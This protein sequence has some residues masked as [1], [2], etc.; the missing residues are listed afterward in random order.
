MP[1]GSNNRLNE[2]SANRNNGNRLFDSQN[3]N[4]GGYNKGDFAT[5]AFNGNGQS[6][7]VFAGEY[8]DGQYSEVYLEGSTI[9][10]EWTAQHGCGGNEKDDPHKLNCNMVIQYTCNSNDKVD[11]AEKVILMDGRN[12]NTPDDPNNLGDVDAK[13][14]QNN[15]NGRGRHEHEG[16]YYQCENRKRATGLFTAD[17]KL[18]GDTSKYTRQNPNG[19]RRGLECPEERDYYPYWHPT[20]WV[21]VAYLTDTPEDCNKNEAEG[22]L[23]VVDYSQNVAMKYKCVKNTNDNNEMKKIMNILTKTACEAEGGAWKGYT[24]G[25]DAPICRQGE[26][27]RVN[28]LGNGK[29][30]QPLTFNWT[31]PAMNKLGNA[32]AIKDNVAKCVLR[33]RYNI[34]TDDY[35]TRR[36]NS[37]F[38]DKPGKPSPVTQNP[39][40]DVGLNNLQGLRLAI[41]TAQ[42]GRTFQDRSHSFYVKKRPSVPGA[43]AFSTAKIRNLNV[44]GKRGNIVQTFP[45]VEYDFTPNY[46]HTSKNEYIHLQWTGSNTHN[47][48]NPAG[49]GQAGDAGEGTGG[50]DRQN[51]VPLVSRGTN[52]PLP[53]GAGDAKVADLSGGDKGANLFNNFDCWAPKTQSTK[54]RGE[55][56]ADYMKE[57]EY[58]KLTAENCA[59]WLATGGY[60]KK[61]AEIDQLTGNNKLNP[62][63][64]NAPASL[65]GGL[66]LKAKKDGE[67]HYMNTRNNNFSNRSQKGTIMVGLDVVSTFA[68]N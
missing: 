12:T 55:Y 34:S 31:L 65:H 61:E 22:Y 45:S 21:D 20:P 15:G 53:Y 43:T 16:W 46:M 67:Y 63:L 48:G 6:T 1:R 39:T 40:V 35:D 32:V 13:N 57:T 56:N 3:N 44:R 24:H 4:R 49:D 50:T 51:M 17:Q 29:N 28:H 60:I 9:P 59:T 10:V 64:D 19:N 23:G 2:K 27:S 58:V 66:L 14:A 68:W 8:A 30:G 41:N 36:T 26:W 18:K 54:S 5:Q 52:Y 11:Y 42:F 33:L 38:N 62:T 47:N 37:S 7:K 25:V